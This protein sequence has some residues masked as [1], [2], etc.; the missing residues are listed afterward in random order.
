DDLMG[1]NLKAPFFLSQAAAPHLKASRGCIVNLS[2]I[3]GMRTLKNHPVYTAAKAGLISLTK[4]LAREL[5]PEVRVNAVAPGAILWPE[6][7]LDEMAK[8]RIVSRIPLKQPGSPEHVASTV[9]F[10]IRDADYITG[11]I[12]AV[13]GGR[14]VV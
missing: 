4:A 9:R 11:Q 7:D 2:D 12:I 14:L 6:N 5:A 8:Q 3:H 13:D 10:L 1:T